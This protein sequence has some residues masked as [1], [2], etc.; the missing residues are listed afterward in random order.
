MRS[1]ANNKLD[2]DSYQLF[3]EE[4]AAIDLELMQNNETR[5]NSTFLMI[6]RAIRKREHIDHFVT[7]LDTKVAESRQRVPVQDQLSPQDWI[8]L[9]EIQSLLKPLYEITMRCQGW[10]KEGRHGALWEVMVG[11]EYLLN[12]F[13]EQKLFFSPPDAAVR[14][15][16][17]AHASASTGRAWQ[18]LV[19]CLNLVLLINFQDAVFC[20]STR[21]ADARN[22]CHSILGMNIPIYPCQPRALMITTGGAYRSLSIIA[23][24]SLMSITVFLANRHFTRL[25]LFFTHVGTCLGWRRIGRATSSLCGYGTLRTVCESSLNSSIHAGS[26]PGWQEARLE[27]RRVERS[28]ANSTSGCRAVIGACWRK[29]MSLGCI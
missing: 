16:R 11:M 27:K 5:W 24:Q 6:Q 19:V 29:K 28:P 3:E 8:Q 10:A 20:D 12:F 17:D 2:H 26:S 14:E 1:L 22:N 25:P 23:G 7:Y 21:I 18:S 9:A 15:P 13:E 4:R